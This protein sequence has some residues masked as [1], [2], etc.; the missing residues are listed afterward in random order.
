MALFLIFV[1]K[2]K[3]LLKIKKKKKLPKFIKLAKSK[4]NVAFDTD[5]F[6]IKAKLPFI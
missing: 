3:H 6:I 1:K 5:F 4:V 2:V